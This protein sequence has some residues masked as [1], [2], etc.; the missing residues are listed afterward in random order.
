M[1]LY[2]LGVSHPKP[3]FEEMDMTGRAVALADELGLTDKHVFFNFGWV[4][5]ERAPEL[6]AGGRHRR[7]RALRRRRDPLLVPD[8]HPRLLLGRAADA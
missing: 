1:K 3:G 5:Y 2:F 6:P 7:L 8:P 4:P